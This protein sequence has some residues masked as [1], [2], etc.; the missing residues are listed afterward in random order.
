MR[1]T[2]EVGGPGWTVKNDPRRTRLGTF[3]RRYSLDEIPQFI[4]VL[5]GDMSIVGP[6]PEQVKMV[7]EFSRTYPRYM[8]RHREKAGITGWAQ[9]NGLRGDTSIEER[10]RYDL[11]Y[12]ENWSVLF[13]L[14]IILKTL[15]VIFT[16]KNAY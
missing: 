12:V 3:M 9:V 11:Y 10:I 13:D 6:R 15:I 8:R 2:S 4:N 7:E 16:D 5:L 1:S 14:K